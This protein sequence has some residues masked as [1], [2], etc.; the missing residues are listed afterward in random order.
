[1]FLQVDLDLLGHPKL[2]RLASEL[3]VDEPRA[4]WHLL[5]FW[6][7]AMRYAPDG[8]VTWCAAVDIAKGSDWPISDAARLVDVLK[9]D[10]HRGHGFLDVVRSRVLVHDW[11]SYGGKVL[12]KREHGRARQQRHRDASRNASRNGDVTPQARKEKTRKENLPQALPLVVVSD[13]EFDLWW[14]KSERVGSKA[15]ARV[16]YV[17]WREQG[18]SHSDL[19]ASIINDR[20][21]CHETATTMR[22]AGTFLSHRDKEGNEINRWQEWVESG[23][24]GSGATR[25]D[26]RQPA[27]QRRVCSSCGTTMTPVFIEHDDGT[28]SPSDRMSCPQGCIDS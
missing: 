2:A 4:L 21:H 20:R 7:F 28:A 5:C 26:S 6:R 10:L 24:H 27:P 16:K 18:A 19:L 17:W 9:A 3:G 12:R 23:Q 13:A 14:T 1:M 11:E 8:D 25:T 15:D 22:H